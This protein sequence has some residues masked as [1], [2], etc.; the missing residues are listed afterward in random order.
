[1]EF[2]RDQWGNIKL[3]PII[4]HIQSMGFSVKDNL[5]SYFSSSDQVFVFAGRDPLPTQTTIPIE[6]VDFN[7]RLTIKCRPN[8]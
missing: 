6:D 7:Q 1:V 4:E 8:T 3:T 5:I 2:E